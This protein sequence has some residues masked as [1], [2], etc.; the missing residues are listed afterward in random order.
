MFSLGIVSEAF[1]GIILT[2][3]TWV[4]GL[5]T[6]AYKIFMAIASAR[7]LSSDAYTTI[8]NKVYIIVG[9][10]MLFVLAYAI[11]KA[12]I[13][14]DQLTKG[15]MAG[16]KIL[17]SIAITVIGLIV[18]PLI[19][20][21]AYM[22][23][24]K[25]LEDDILGKLFFR[26]GDSTVDVAGVGTVNYD[27]ELKHTG[28]GIAAT[29]VWMAFFYPAE[30]MDPDEIMADPDILRLHAAGWYAG[31]AAAAAV[32]IAGVALSW[33]TFGTSLIIAGGAAAACAV[34][35]AQS[36]AADDAD[37]ALGDKD[38][39]SLTDAYNLTASGGS[40]GIYQAFIE[41]LDEDE[42]KYTWF[43]STVCG[44]FVCYAFVSY[45]IDMGLRAAKLAYYQIIAPV[46]LI[47]NVMPKNGDRLGK[48][49]KAV[50]S[51]FLEVFVRIS[52][53]YIVV[54]IIAHLHELFSTVGALWNNE[55]LSDI[56]SLITMALL[57]IGLVLFAKQA[58]K[59]ISDTFGLSAGS[60][61]EGLNIMKKLRDGEVFTAGAVAGSS[62]KSGVQNA[63]RS[64]RNNK[65]KGFANK[66]LRAGG[67]FVGGSITGGTRAGV[68]RVRSGKPVAG[69]R[70]A[71]DVADKTA[72]ELHDKRQ[73][74]DDFRRVNDTFDKQVKA[75][76]GSV[77]SK[78]QHWA[79]GDVDTGSIDRQAA[80]FDY[81]K[82]F[83]GKLEGTVGN[84]SKIKEANRYVADLASY[85]GAQIYA[86]TIQDMMATGMSAEA[87]AKELGF[88]G[89]TEEIARISA[90]N[91]GGATAVTM[92][93]LNAA[94]DAADERLKTTKKDAVSRKLAEAHASGVDNDTSRMAKQLLSSQEFLKYAAEFDQLD[95]GGDKTFGE[96]LR[97]NFGNEVT[98]NGTVDFTKLFKEQ[99]T[100]IGGAPAI[101]L[102]VKG[103][104][105]ISAKKIGLSNDETITIKS[106][107]IKDAVYDLAAGEVVID[108]GGTY[109]KQRIKI[110]DLKGSGFEVEG[111]DTLTEVTITGNNVT[112]RTK[113][114]S[115][116]TV[117]AKAKDK[118]ESK[119]DQFRNSEF[120]VEAQARKR[121]AEKNKNK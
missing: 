76:A 95:F 50:F 101:E 88:K 16:N 43:I 80:A 84:D 54:Y 100:T 5:I 104:T 121:E 65:G 41:P 113:G 24:G 30:G 31:C 90:I 103:G 119:G 92:S 96:Y 106:D 32:A 19:F 42:I 2:L 21:L 11:L 29:T 110:D 47:L 28:G 86:K 111:S 25:M 85:N 102:K 34:G 68:G 23:Q 62:L 73:K 14:P 15:D 18:T 1:Y 109:G 59:I 12:I 83:S 114:T 53:V 70:D 37:A 89:T 33:F 27:E 69:V 57:I 51:T 9:V 40:F 78:I 67:S 79:V 55:N 61:L 120:F 46:P 74:R 91:T 60:G 58:P 52:V 82:D 38:E 35:A 48:F 98:K 36:E 93:D 6:S 81:M 39:I 22:A 13:D 4:Y 71:R 112:S 56:E 115:K 94:R 63:T 77:S 20:D 87:V 99:A 49:V 97:D 17:K 72:R 8:A 117:A 45:A 105:K 107:D 118:G 116:K 3:D 108:F 66:V 75:M 64:W 26:T 7:I 44:G 10:G